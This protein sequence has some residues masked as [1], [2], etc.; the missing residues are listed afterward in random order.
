MQVTQRLRAQT[1]SGDTLARIG[2]DEFVVVASFERQD[3]ISI[4]ARR[5]IEALT[6]PFVLA[7]G[8]LK[9]EYPSESQSTQKMAPNSRS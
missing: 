7:A 5:L 6:Q 4:L 3:D 2:G 8:R 1:R 9:L